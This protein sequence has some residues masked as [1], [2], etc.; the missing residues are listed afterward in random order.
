MIV[1][2]VFV[3]FLFR[4]KINRLVKNQLN[5][6]LNAKVQYKDFRLS[7]ITS[8][9][10]FKFTMNDFYVAGINE[11]EGDT[12]L[13]F[14]SLNLYF[15]LW[16]VIVMKDLKIKAI[17]LQEPNL[18]ALIL[19]NGKVNWEIIKPSKKLITNGPFSTQRKLSL[20]IKKIE[21]IRANV[22]YDDQQ[23]NIFA[24]LQNCNFLLKGDLTKKNTTVH[25]TSHTDFVNF[26]RAGIPYLKDV[27]IQFDLDADAD[28]VHS[29][30]TFK[31]NS[32]SFNDLALGCNGTLMLRDRN[33]NVD[34]TYQTKK[35][36]FKSV[37]SLVPTMYMKDFAN[38]QS[39]GTLK[40]D[41][42]IKGDYNGKIMPNIGLN[43]VVDKAM[44]KYPALPKSVDNINI[45]LR[46]FFDGIDSDRSTV[47][48]NRFH[49]EISKYY[50]DMILD[51]KHPRTDPTLKATIK[52]NLDI[53]SIKE[54]IP[55]DSMILKGLIDINMNFKGQMSMIKQKKYQNV[56]AKGSVNIIGL[57]YMSPAFLP[58]ITISK[59][60]FYITPKDI[61]ITQLNAT[62][63]K[64]DFNLEGKLTNFITYLFMNDTV[65][66]DLMLICKTLDVNQF[67]SNVKPTPPQLPPQNKQ[68]TMNMTFSLLEI[69]KN[70]DF[71]INSQIGN[72]YFDKLYI[73][74]LTGNVKVHNSKMEVE[75]LRMNMLN[76][77]IT[78]S[79][80]YNTQDRTKPYIV[81]DYKIVNFD[82]PSTLSAFNF[83]KKWVPIAENTKGQFSMNM[84]YS[85]QVDKQIKPLMNTIVGF[86]NLSCQNIEISNDQIFSKIA[87]VIKIDMKVIKLNDV[88]FSFFIK[89]GRLFVNPFDIKVGNAN[90][91]IS[92]DNGLDQSLNYKMKV[93]VP[94]TQFASGL[95]KTA[96]SLLSQIVPKG[97]S[98][99]SLEQTHFDVNIGGSVTKP[100]ISFG[101]NSDKSGRNNDNGQELIT[102]FMQAFNKPV[103]EMS[104][105]ESENIVGDAHRQAEKI[106]S[107]ASLRAM[108]VRKDANATADSIDI[109]S[110]TLSKIEKDKA[111]KTSDKIRKD[112][113]IKAQRI[114]NEANLKASAII[115]KESEY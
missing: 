35:M 111:K 83:V 52:A 71:N 113:E 21:I 67:I 23:R 84:K 78:I 66:A 3:P 70:I 12:L 19:P 49:A 7:I 26:L 94:T 109:Q 103:K 33:I 5:N 101:M 4:G 30:F 48:L 27:T 47:E 32:F 58:G 24:S 82:I 105:N 16:S 62:Y 87:D 104:K 77:S 114:I 11:F 65:H 64:S 38:L 106:K 22:T 81:M 44:F 42:F 93:S 1:I 90:L 55:M 50:L 73:S 25:V 54:V 96:T 6:N 69:P 108:Q 41:G 51:L 75:K 99:N 115:E 74:D 68:D 36:E 63:G 80:Q 76:G 34:L 18:Y 37:L 85:S 39:S 60:A 17:V 89:E 8:F 46:V 15:D 59:A 86:G 40:L 97:I 107:D 56:K 61:D 100:S 112:A 10:N 57:E 31:D 29:K 28:L 45:N 79:G 13:H 43:M 20:N 92:G 14:K 88:V 102:D 110:V 72:I 91:N 53:N 98:I 95:I 2:L 9:P